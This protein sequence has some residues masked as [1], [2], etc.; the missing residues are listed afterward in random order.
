MLR[1]RVMGSA[2][3]W[4]GLAAVLLWG[5]PAARA[6]GKGK[7]VEII[8]DCSGSMKNRLATGETRIAAAKQ[9]VE[10]MVPKLPAQTILAFR[11]Y[12]HQSPTAQHDCQDT[13]ILEGFAP[14]AQNGAQIMQKTKDLTARGYTPITHVLGLAAQD[15]PAQAQEEKIII[16]VSDGKETCPGDPCVAAKALSLAHKVVIHTVGLG[17]D[18]ATKAQLECIARAAGGRYFPAGSAQ[19]LASTLMTAVETSQVRQL[20]K[21]GFGHL[22]V[23]GADLMGHQVT[24]AETGETVATLSHVQDTVK[25]PAGIYSVSVGQ[26][27]WPSVEVQA[28]QTTLLEPGILTVRHAALQGNRVLEPETGQELG[29]VSSSKSSMALMPGEYEVTFGQ[30]RWPIKLE[31]GQKLVLNPGV[32]H[33]QGAKIT[34]HRVLDA[35]GHEVGQVSATMSSIALPPG[36]Y[37]LELEGGRESFELKEG[38]RLE[39]RH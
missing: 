1:W 5:P 22:K 28:D 17:V 36:Q 20:K 19:E 33:L 6:E 9:A 27:L 38:Q 21:K 16:L 34:G 32:L 3:L 4:S 39:F 2:V 12:G 24:N 8:L 10:T 35:Q 15:F 13:Q 23:K 18:T 25:L 30:A 11:A 37:A 7:M 26:A 31:A 29:Q 14:A